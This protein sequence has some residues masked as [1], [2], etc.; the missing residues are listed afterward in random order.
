V[1]HDESYTGVKLAEVDYKMP[2]NDKKAI[3]EK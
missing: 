1:T 3:K 2:V